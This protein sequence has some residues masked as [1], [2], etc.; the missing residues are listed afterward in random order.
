M[1]YDEQCCQRS[2]KAGLPRLLLET[3]VLKDRNAH[4]FIVEIWKRYESDQRPIP[5]ASMLIS[6]NNAL[7]CLLVKDRYITDCTKRDEPLSRLAPG[8]D[9][10][11]AA[12][13]ACLVV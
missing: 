3:V 11:A 4:Y 1:Q 5:C 6:S 13:L 10:N 2:S 8:R 9:L 12:L 7:P